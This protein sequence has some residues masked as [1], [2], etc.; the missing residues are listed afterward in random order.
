MGFVDIPQPEDDIK[1]LREFFIHV[2][3][4]LRG[5]LVRFGE[6]LRETMQGGVM[7]VAQFRFAQALPD[8]DNG[9][10]GFARTEVLPDRIR[11]G[12][13]AVDPRN[14]LDQ[15]DPPII[16]AVVTY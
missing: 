6:H 13:P 2:I 7:L 3:G 4:T 16:P 1:I 9:V 5:L 15:R 8:T 14:L 10:E 12:W 11:N